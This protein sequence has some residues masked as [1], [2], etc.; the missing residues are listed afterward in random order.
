MV[1]I[2]K[3]FPGQ[4]SQQVNMGLDLYEYSERVRSLFTLASDI[5]HMN[6]HTLLT[7]GTLGQI[8]DTRVAQ[9]VITLVNRASSVL[10]EEKG[11]K[12]AAAAGFS[13]GELSAYR[14][15]QVIDDIQ[16]FSI[17][18][19]RGQLMARNAVSAERRYGELAMAAIVGLSFDQVDEVIRQCGQPHVYASNDNSAKQVVIAGLRSSVE[20]IE[21][22]LK[23]LKVRRVIYLN[24]SGP[25]HT[26]LMDEA[27]AE[28]EQF[29]QGIS[30]SKPVIPLYSNVTGKKI[31]SNEDI[32]SLCAR[33]IVSPVR[34][35]A[36][37]ENIAADHP[38]CD[39]VET[40][41]GKVLSGFFRSTSVRCHQAGTVEGLHQIQAMNKEGQNERV[42]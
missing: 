26:P 3:V 37:M 38:V 28:F 41:Y 31:S 40:G 10:L 29:L 8:T 15:A 17:T 11:F 14:E 20:R 25:F 22:L 36:I 1:E 27:R 5:S 6:L 18:A 39:A 16:L 32:R 2:V 21:V 42:L 35:T 23:D 4:G 30:F 33:Q 9:I 34:W 13:L 7:E 24:V 19:K 12:A